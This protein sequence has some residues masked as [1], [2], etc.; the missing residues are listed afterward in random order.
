VGQVPLTPTAKELS[1][2]RGTLG[3][4][5][6]DI[7]AL[8]GRTF[9]GASPEAGGTPHPTG[10]IKSPAPAEVTQA[11]GHAEEDLA[12]QLDKVLTG[13]P[14]EQRAQAGGRTV[15]MHIDQAVCSGCAQGIDSTAR[16]GVLLQLSKLH[17][18]IVFEVT[19]DDVSTVIRL[20]GGKL[21]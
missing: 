21:L 16:A 11:H 5:Q 14:A 13:L 12:N 8:E 2:A 4:A 3:V 10:R 6:S 18:D 20:F 9:R 17:P 7:P 1:R 15:Y 19:A